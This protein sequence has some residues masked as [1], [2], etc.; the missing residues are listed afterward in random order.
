MTTDAGALSEHT[1][2]SSTDYAN[3]LTK[4][5]IVAVAHFRLT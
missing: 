3:T 5:T 2:E 4:G 1:T